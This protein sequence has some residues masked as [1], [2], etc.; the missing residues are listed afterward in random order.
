MANTLGEII[1]SLKESPKVE[2]W[3]YN[4]ITF[5]YTHIKKPFEEWLNEY[6]QQGWELVD[7]YSFG[8]NIKQCIFKR[9]IQ[10]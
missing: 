1:D 10:Q 4:D 9:K 7:I 2:K 3:E 6:G 5:D 8:L